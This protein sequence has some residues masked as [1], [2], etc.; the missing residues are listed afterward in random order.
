MPA[1]DDAPVTR[2]ELKEVLAEFADRIINRF[3]SRFKEIDRRFDELQ[4][5][6]AKL[7]SQMTEV[8]SQMAEVQ[9]QIVEVRNRLEK[10]EAGLS[11]LRKQYERMEIDL[12]VLRAEIVSLEDR[13]KHVEAGLERVVLTMFKF[14]NRDDIRTEQIAKLIDDHKKLNGRFILA[15]SELAEFKSQYS[16]E[17]VQTEIE[18]VRR[19]TRRLEERVAWLE[20]N[21][22][23]V[24]AA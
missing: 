4:S 13:L 6:I 3:E 22:A 10:V 18:E 23:G 9:S 15:Q 5:Q 21:R 1:K 24:S 17:R 2:A 7:Q 11:E 8:Q 14:E 16:P 12:G 19:T 20:K